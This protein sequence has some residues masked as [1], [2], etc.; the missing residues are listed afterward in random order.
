VS[1]N[2]EP[3]GAGRIQL[4]RGDLIVVDGEEIDVA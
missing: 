4:I 3:L 2:R 1:F